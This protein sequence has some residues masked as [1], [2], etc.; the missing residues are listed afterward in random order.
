MVITGDVTQIDL[1]RGKKS[2]LMEAERILQG[3]EDIGFIF[4]QEADVV[5]HSLVQKIIS[6]YSMH[7]ELSKG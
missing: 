1:P 7:D 6:A 2:G 4:L 3:I 5:R